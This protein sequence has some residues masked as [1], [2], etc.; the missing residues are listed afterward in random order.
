MCSSDLLP[1]ASF[2]HEQEKINRRWPAAVEYITQHR[3][4]EFLGGTSGEVGIILQG[5]LYNTLIRALELLGLADSTGQT[6]LP[7]YVLNVTYPLIENEVIGFCR[8]KQAVL[9]VEEGQPEYLE[10]NLHAILRRADVATKVIG[11]DVL[12]KAGEYTGDVILRG[13]R[14]FMRAYALDTLERATPLLPPPPAE[15]PKEVQALAPLLPIRP[16]GFCTM[17]RDRKSVV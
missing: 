17:N 4:N 15:L 10:Q 14:A 3:L 13:V 7:L 5:G 12:P 11:K 1:P 16:A 2:L 6:Q 8:G 9:I